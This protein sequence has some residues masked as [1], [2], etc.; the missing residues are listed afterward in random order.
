MEKA[1]C[2]ITDASGI[3]IEYV[4]MF[5]RP[6]L[7]LDDIDKVHNNKFMDFKD[8]TTIDE[9]IKKTAFLLQRSVRAKGNIS[10][11][12]GHQ[13]GDDFVVITRPKQA[14]EVAKF[15]CS[16]FDSEILSA[17][18][19]KEDLERGYILEV[20][21]R[22]SVEEGSE[23]K[24]KFPLMAISLAGISTQKRDFADYFECMS[25]AAGVK[26]EAKQTAGSSYIIQE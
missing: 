10:D 1:K 19:R 26:K 21:R 11:F 15:I 16:F 24:A 18:Y 25:A 13:G 3:A 2:L 14:E 12:V 7:Y 22:R 5:K 6:V 9:T 23:V 4:L 17:L 20:D 8:I